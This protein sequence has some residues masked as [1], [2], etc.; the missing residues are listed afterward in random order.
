MH[1][2]KMDPLEGAQFIFG[3]AN[4]LHKGQIIFAERGS[5]SPF[6]LGL[7]PWNILNIS[8]SSNF[9]TLLDY[10]LQRRVSVAL[11]SPNYVSSYY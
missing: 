7:R 4:I 8:F 3:N 10:T 5:V 9:K 1:T 2:G 6:C 11:F